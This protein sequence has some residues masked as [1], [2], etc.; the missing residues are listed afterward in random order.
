MQKFNRIR[1]AIASGLSVLATIAGIISLVLLFTKKDLPGEAEDYVYAAWILLTAATFVCGGLL[2]LI[3]IAWRC[4]AVGLSMAPIPAN[5]FLWAIFF[6]FSAI[7]MLFVP[8]IP[9]S[10][11]ESIY[12][13]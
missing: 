9:V 11:A 6:V 2:T 13:Q 8:I 12:G 1:Y 7:G 10:E 3:K 4:S 5:V